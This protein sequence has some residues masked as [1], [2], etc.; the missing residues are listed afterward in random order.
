MKLRAEDCNLLTEIYKYLYSEGCRKDLA[1][2]LLHVINRIN[3]ER[4]KVRASAPRSRV[5]DE[6]SK[7]ELEQEDKTIMQRLLDAGYPVDEMDHH[8][9]DL[10]VYVTPVSTRV[11]ECWCNEHQCN[12]SWCFPTFR[13]QITGRLMYDCVFQY[14]GGA[15]QDDKS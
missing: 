2:A 12:R 8:E 5:M 9:S 7:R 4:E 10:Y 15:D 6:R 13:D 1:A 11:I 14:I 3:A